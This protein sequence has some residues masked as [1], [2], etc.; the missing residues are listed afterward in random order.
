MVTTLYLVR[1]GEAEGNLLGLFLGSS[2][3]TKHAALTQ[4]GEKQ[5][6]MRSL[7]LRDIHFDAIY[8]SN[9]IRTR[10]TAEILRGHRNIE[11]HV[12]PLFIERTWGN[13]E[14]HPR[15]EVQRQHKDL[16]KK[17][18]AMDFEGQWTYVFDG[19]VESYDEVY[20]RF[21]K[22][23]NKVVSENPGKTILIVTHSAVIRSFLTKIDRKYF[24]REVD[25][26]AMAKVITENGRYK[27]L[28]TKGIN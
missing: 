4:K 18:D 13:F 17:Y 25:Y 5:A 23:V 28:E 12:E 27:I 9:L 16:F 11:I 20:K 26:V 22:G 8:S 10:Q 7:D 1:H 14:L 15:K 2:D 3:D 19:S 24:L 21:E 6:A